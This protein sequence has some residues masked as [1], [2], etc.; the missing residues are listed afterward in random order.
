MARVHTVVAGRALAGVK[1][2]LSDC[3]VMSITPPKWTQVCRCPTFSFP[4]MHT[5][6]A[7]MPP[8]PGPH[9]EL[10]HA[11]TWTRRLRKFCCIAAASPPLWS[12]HTIQQPLPNTV[13]WLGRSTRVETYGGKGKGEGFAVA[14]PT[15]CQTPSL[16]P[17][18]MP[19]CLLCRQV[20]TV[21]YIV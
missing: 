11:H 6:S 12:H 7:F 2:Q 5:P 8:H 14:F 9:I 1:E 3:D 17:S 21:T 15:S 16:L 18:I 20:Q 10:V 13:P 4:H 19:T